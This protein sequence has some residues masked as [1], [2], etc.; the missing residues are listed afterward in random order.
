MVKISG[1]IG[2][3]LSDIIYLG[4]REELRLYLPDFAYILYDFSSYS[5]EE[6]KGQ[7]LTR[8]CLDLF[9]H[10]FDPD[11]A[12]HLRKATPLLR[13]LLLEGR[14]GLEAIELIAT[15]IAN[16]S[17]ISL[18]ELANI[19]ET[20][21]KETGGMVMSLASTLE[22]KGIQK[23]IQ[24]GM[25]KGELIG[26]IRTEQLRKGLPMSDKKELEKLSVEELEK[27]LKELT[28]K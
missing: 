19:L 2:G 28:G 20:V 17:D 13:E 11:L 16:A 5:D 14:T 23:G 3:K 24:Q 22:E 6:I 4:D 21:S 15:Y 9:K 8:I 7:I 1:T 10:I 27:K 26:D 25:A 18:E 12:D